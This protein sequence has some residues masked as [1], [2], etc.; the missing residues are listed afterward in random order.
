MVQQVA[1]EEG[2]VLTLAVLIK[3][4]DLFVGPMPSWELI[5]RTRTTSHRHKIP[6]NTPSGFAQAKVTTRWHL[7]I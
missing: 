3:G 4:T 7:Q 6:C 5:A 2:P 1:G